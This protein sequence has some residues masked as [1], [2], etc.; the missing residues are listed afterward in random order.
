MSGIELEPVY[1][2]HDAE[3]PGV[4]PYTRGPH[5]SMYRSRL[6]TMRMFAGFGIATDTN[7]RFKEIIRSGGTGCP[8]PL[9]CR[10]S[11]VS[12][13]TIRWPWARWDAA[14]WRSTRSATCR[15]LYDGIDLSS[16]TTSMTINSPAAVM[17]ALFVA[18]AEKAGVPARQ[19]RRHAAERHLKGV[20]GPEGVRLPAP[21][22]PCA[23]CA[24]PCLCRQRCPSGTRSPSRATTLERPARRPP[25]SSPSP[26]PTASPTW[27]WRGGRS[28]RRRGGATVSLLLQRPHRLLRGDRQVP[29]GEETL[30]DLD[31]GPLRREGAKVASC[32]FTPRRPAS[33]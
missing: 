19:A 15:D 14:A 27:N 8:R 7:R 21:C 26:W 4:Y 31:E 11:W 33:P 20:P 30:G 12:T 22:S 25:K 28:Q 18:Q 6:W 13:A 32:A 23:S 16:I 10:R 24:T 17:L 5:A 1:G 29:R 9:T 3:F 2:P